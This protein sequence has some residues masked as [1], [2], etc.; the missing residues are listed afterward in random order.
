MEDSADVRHDSSSDSEVLIRS[1]QPPERPSESVARK[2]RS[3]P[4]ATFA[5][6]VYDGPTGG[7]KTKA[8]PDGI[9]P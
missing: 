7:C 8:S 1:V 5:V 6:Q 9:S 4:L 3:V 2:N